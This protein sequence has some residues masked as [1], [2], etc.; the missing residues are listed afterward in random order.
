MQTGVAATARLGNF[1]SYP[2][3]LRE[4]LSAAFDLRTYLIL[5]CKILHIVKK[6]NTIDWY[7]S[8][9]GEVKCSGK[10]KE[11]I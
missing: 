5:P 9:L 7:Y 6:N 2:P 4:K 3:C 10:I 1:F 8:G 11:A